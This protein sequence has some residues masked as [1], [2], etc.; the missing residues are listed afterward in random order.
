MK[1]SEFFPFRKQNSRT[2]FYPMVWLKKLDEMKSNT[3]KRGKAKSAKE[4]IESTNDEPE[5]IEIKQEETSIDEFPLAFCCTVCSIFFPTQESLDNHEIDHDKLKN[6]KNTCTRCGQ[7][8]KDTASLKF[9]IKKKHGEPQ[10]TSS[11]KSKS[12]VKKRGR[13]PGVPNS[14]RKKNKP[15]EFKCETCSKTFKIKSIYL[16]HLSRHEEGEY[17]CKQCDKKFRLARD[18][19]RHEK[20]HFLPS[21][22]CKECDYET[23]VGTAL[24]IHMLRHADPDEMPFKCDECDKRFHRQTDLQQHR[25][26]HTGDKPFQCTVCE[27]AYSLKRQLTAHCRTNHPEMKPDKPTS[28]TCDICQRVLATRRSLIRHIKSHNPTKS[29]LC[30]FCVCSLFTL[31]SILA[32]PWQMNK[33]PKD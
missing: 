5:V 8:F 1:S 29:Y 23:T 33:F 14:T 7:I 30:D 12:K 10:A 16:K 27:K 2:T 11:S 17:N 9:H 4:N 31:K 26:I 19:S 6:R 24:Q 28:T 21:Y 18:L 15:D 3:E 22:K 20:T 32:S 13:P 25:N